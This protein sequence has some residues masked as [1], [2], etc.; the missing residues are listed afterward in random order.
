MSSNL[1]NT[2]DVTIY[3]ARFFFLFF[4]R[5]P[6]RRYRRPPDQPRR[7]PLDRGGRPTGSGHGVRGGGP[8][9]G[10]DTREAPG[11]KAGLTFFYNDTERSCSGIK[12][13]VKLV[14][15]ETP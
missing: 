11:R 8:G 5:P 7:Q 6:V 10:N 14:F 2:P 15:G 9:S 3:L 1:N 4:Y 12:E 13:I